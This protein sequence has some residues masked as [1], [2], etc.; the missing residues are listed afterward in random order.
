MDT[1]IYQGPNTHLSAD[2]LM[3]NLLHPS[4]MIAV[5]TET[6]SLKNKT[7]I[8]IGIAINPNEAY[9]LTVFPEQCPKLLDILELLTHTD[10]TKLYHNA[11]F[12]LDVLFSLTME[13]KVSPPDVNSIEDTSLLSHINGER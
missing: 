13:L 2:E 1:L 10:I 9:Y 12:D 7:C 4:G 8:G 6:I 11:T 5:D 3:D